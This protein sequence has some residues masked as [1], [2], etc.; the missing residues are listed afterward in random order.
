MG[1][2]RKICSGSNSGGV[3]GFYRILVSHWSI[4]LWFNW[5]FMLKISRE[6][7][8]KCNKIDN[9]GEIFDLLTP[10]GDPCALIVCLLKI[11]GTFILQFN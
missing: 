8:L 9:L 4:S 11:H 3:I 5:W 10:T 1:D 6:K 2:K 7:L